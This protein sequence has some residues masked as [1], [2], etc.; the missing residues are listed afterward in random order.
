M[1]TRERWEKMDT[2]AGFPRDVKSTVISGG[3]YADSKINFSYKERTVPTVELRGALAEMVR[4]FSQIKADL[5]DARTWLT[6]AEE[7]LRSDPGMNTSGEL[8]LDTAISPTARGLFIGALAF[9]G[10]SFTNCPGRR[11][12]MEEKFLDSRF[13]VAHQSFM[14]YRNAYAAH[15]GQEKIERSSLYMLLHPEREKYHSLVLRVEGGRPNLDIAAPDGT[16]FEDLIE[17]A[18]SVAQSRKVKM[19]EVLLSTKVYPRGIAFW[20]DVARTDS[21]IEL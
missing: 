19:S 12:R 16:L 15:S 8:T 13:H 1:V 7:L 6:T 21:P 17:H 11:A 14:T 9:Y 4:G 10:K 20:Y 5:N 2:D 3:R 18:A